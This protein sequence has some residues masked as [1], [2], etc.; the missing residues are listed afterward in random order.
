[1]DSPGAT[2]RGRSAGG[3]A[4]GS[5]AA[6]ASVATALACTLPGEAGGDPAMGARKPVRSLIVDL[7]RA[8]SVALAT[9]GISKPLTVR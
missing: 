8:A 1:M 6:P 5:A 9:K 3:G 7:S 2:V 4:V